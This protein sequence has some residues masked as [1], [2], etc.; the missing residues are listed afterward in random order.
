[1]ELLLIAI[2]FVWLVIVNNKVERLEKKLRGSV[3]AEPA[4]SKLLFKNSQNNSESEILAK[5][6]LPEVVKKTSTVSVSSEETAV[7]WLNRIGVLALVLGIGFFFK[8][9]IDRGWINEW[10]RVVVG[11]II[12]GLFVYL[13]NMWKEKHGTRAFALMGGGFAVFY[14]SVY[15]AQNFYHLVP[16][17]LAFFS[18]LVI[19]AG[20]LF[21]SISNN[22]KLL[23][24]FVFFGA[25]AA[26]L[27]FGRLEDH[28]LFLFIYLAA[29][30]VCAL[31][32]LSKKYWLEL[33]FYVLAGTILDFGVWA[34]A[35]TNTQNTYTSLIFVCLSTIL[36]VF[37][38][39][40]FTQ[41]HGKDLQHEREI[42]NNVTA[43]VVLSGLFYALASWGLLHDHFYHLLA[44]V[45]LLGFVLYYLAY[46]FIDRL[47]YKNANYSLSFFGSLALVSA[48]YF[49]FEGRIL[50]L[51]VLGISL[52]GSLVGTLTKRIEIQYWALTAG[53]ASLLRSLY[54]PYVEY[55]TTFLFNGKFALMLA[56]IFGLFISTKAL[57]NSHVENTE[58]LDVIGSLL[59]WFIVSWEIMRN[60]QGYDER[61]MRNL[62]LSLWS[63][64]YGLILMAVGSALHS[65][66]FRKVAV[67]MFGLSIIKVFLYDV[68]TL[69]TGY[70][71]VSFIV[72]G[73][74]LLTVSF[75]FQKNKERIMEFIE[76]GH[77][78]V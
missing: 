23:G 74:I 44:V 36:M 49:Q 54:L 24:F 17:W 71:I 34:F 67:L 50:V 57:K 15:A 32:A 25:Y 72:L 4:S 51:V 20:S 38:A 29:I 31:M 78:V 42:D 22:S 47:E 55:D 39:T 63:I 12:G 30:Q 13:G 26:P 40:I 37:G 73:I 6:V 69:D 62:F 27:F 9:A 14:F 8:L 28:Q 68:Q 58:P 60:F 10:G 45:S 19:A 1:M 43:I 41:Q 2:L 66:I 77:S 7:N 75:L 3:Q 33:L 64:F 52:L 16:V 48:A 61:S 53:I 5:P 46:L 11:L 21:L 35:Y 56:N 76:G 70:R 59:V 65:S 18:Y